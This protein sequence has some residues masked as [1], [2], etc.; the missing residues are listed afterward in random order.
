MLET[1]QHN[2][3]YYIP[4]TPRMCVRI[5]SSNEED[6]DAELIVKLVLVHSLK[7]NKRFR[8]KLKVEKSSFCWIDASALT[9]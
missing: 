5:P 3:T 8:L 7:D 1:Q 4:S 6:F 2:R 9:I